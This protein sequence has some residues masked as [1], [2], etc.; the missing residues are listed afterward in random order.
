MTMYEKKEKRTDGLK[1]DVKVTRTYEFH[2]Q[3]RF[4]R[5]SERIERKKRHAHLYTWSERMR[6]N[7]RQRECMTVEEKEEE[8]AAWICCMSIKRFWIGKKTTTECIISVWS[9]DCCCCCCS[10]Y[11]CMYARWI[12]YVS[13]WVW[14]CVWICGGAPVCAYG[15]DCVWKQ[16]AVAAWLIQLPA[17]VRF[18]EIDWAIH[19]WVCVFFSEHFK[20]NRASWIN[21]V[22]FI[23]IIALL[24]LFFCCS[25]FFSSL[26]ASLNS[27]QLNSML[28]F[29][30]P[31]DF[32]WLKFLY[33]L[34]L[35]LHS[36]S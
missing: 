2:K 18:N 14:M 8:S 11:V 29:D 7:E 21:V 36:L 23:I 33:K 3:A 32:L 17:V 5:Q 9:D 16:A 22:F 13:D 35:H 34:K 24:L 10:M 31:F 12:A 27:T 4:S 25:S 6:W 1:T 28:H 20:L 26:F 19:V 15:C 30:L